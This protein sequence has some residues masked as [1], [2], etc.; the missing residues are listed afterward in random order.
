M[1]VNRRGVMALL[2]PPSALRAGQGAR[3][4][5]VALVAGSL[6]LVG[7]VMP[8]PDTCGRKAYA[9]LIGQPETVLEGVAFAGPVRVIRPGQP[10]TMDLVPARLNIALDADDIIAGLSCG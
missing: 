6:L 1:R 4:G 5:L 3:A 10:V 2:L 9:E 8:E 7:C